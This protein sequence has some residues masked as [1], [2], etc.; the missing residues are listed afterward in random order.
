MIKSFARRGTCRSSKQCTP[1]HPTQ[2]SVRLLLS[3]SSSHQC[4]IYAQ[5]F[6]VKT[7]R[8]KCS[9]LQSLPAFVRAHPLRFGSILPFGS[10][11]GLVRQNQLLLQPSVHH[12]NTRRHSTKHQIASHSLLI[13]CNPATGHAPDTRRSPSQRYTYRRSMELPKWVSYTVCIGHRI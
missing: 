2:L 3:W 11:S 7:I 12:F 4:S 13:H 10:E 6:D 5:A 1:D 9:M 8:M